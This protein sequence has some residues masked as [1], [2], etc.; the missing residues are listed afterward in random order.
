MGLIGANGAGK[1]TFI[2]ALTGFVPSSGRGSTVG[3]LNLPPHER[4]ASG[5]VRSWQSIELFEDLTVRENVMVAV[6]HVS[7]RGSDRGPLRE[8][9][10]TPAAGARRPSARHGGHRRLRQQLPR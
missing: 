1:T 2:D 3:T 9:A 8:A 6:E 10:Q 7:V 4:V 5:L